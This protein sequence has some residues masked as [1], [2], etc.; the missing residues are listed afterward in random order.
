MPGRWTVLVVAA[1]AAM[2][3]RLS[4]AQQSNTDSGRLLYDQACQSCHGPDGQ[5]ERAPALDTGRFVH[6]S[7]DADLF[8]T[9]RTGLP[10]TQMPP[11]AQLPDEQVWQLV[12][13]LRSLS[14]AATGL[15]AS[16]PVPVSVTTRDGRQLRGT[17]L[18][19]DTFSVQFVDASGAWLFFDKSTRAVR[20]V[21]AGGVGGERLARA[22]AEPQNWLMYW[23]DY[24]S[25]HYSGL[26]EIDAR[27]VG[28]LRVAWTFAM[29]G[30]SVLEA[31]PIVVDGVM[32]STQP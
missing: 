13:Y 5:G 19:E 6:G 7:A 21:E 18:N 22:S 4:T 10:G 2:T 1:V 15:G 11:F 26:N 20:R 17:R 12:S 16:T 14:A 30:E 23:G 8:H 28:R 3:G 31:T 32:Y 9:I 27:N 29:P 25:T 24:R